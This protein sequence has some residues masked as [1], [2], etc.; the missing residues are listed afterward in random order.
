MKMKKLMTITLLKATTATFALLA[1][2]W[3]P[4]TAL[5][6]TQND[7]ASAD[8]KVL[9]TYPHGNF[10]EN[11][12]VQEDGRLLFTNYPTKSI[13]V[14][15]LNGD[16]ETFATLSAYP[17][18]LISTDDGYLVAASGKSLLLGE[19]VIGTQ[20]FLLLDRSGNEVGQFDA[21][22][23]MYLNGMVR[24]NSD[25]FLAA[26]SLS[27]NIWQINPKTQEITS[28]VQDELLSPQVDQELFIPGANGLKRKSD[29]LIVSNTSK[30]T[31]LLIEIGEDDKP[32]NKPELISTVGM[33]DD[34]WVRD[35]GSILFT[36]HEE[37]VKSLSPSGEV[38]TVLADGAGGA[39]AIAPYPL[40]QDAKFVLINDGNLYFGK[41]DLVEVLLLTIE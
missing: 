24:L 19:D 13:E 7:A 33:I 2:L 1:S 38:T 29:D 32:A 6:Q 4:A 25:L 31:L 3:L 14:L 18:S 37:T 23:I 17:L 41:K 20:Q 21:P 5:S 27:G 40:N 11:L 15:E 28:W 36:T 16:T 26:D 8:L 35:D 10:L 39:T 12:E 30:G 9:A 22:Q 34:F